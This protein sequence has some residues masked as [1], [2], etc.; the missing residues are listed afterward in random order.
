M[1]CSSR[2]DNTATRSPRLQRVGK[3]L[4][5]IHGVH[6]RMGGEARYAVG[7]NFIRALDRKRKTDHTEN[8][9]VSHDS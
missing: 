9:V 2:L 3:R 5:E 8:G 7:V 1:L 4:E 6:C